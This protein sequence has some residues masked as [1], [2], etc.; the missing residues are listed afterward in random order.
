MS[1]MLYHTSYT[2]KAFITIV[3]RCIVQVKTPKRTF[4]SCL[5]MFWPEINP[6]PSD[7]STQGHPPTTT[8]T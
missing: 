5:L 1:N 2:I 3:L 7:P 8:A 6:K 4:G